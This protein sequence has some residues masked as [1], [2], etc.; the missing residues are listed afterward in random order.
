MGVLW[1]KCHGH[2]LLYDQVIDLT[3]LWLDKYLINNME[4]IKWKMLFHY[5]SMM[6]LY[7]IDSSYGYVFIENI[8]F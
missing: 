5:F 6:F 7:H 4:M 1:Y 2:F 3:Y 8:E